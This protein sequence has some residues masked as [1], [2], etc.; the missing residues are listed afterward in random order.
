[1]L[2]FLVARGEVAIVGRQG[3]Q[4]IW[5]LASRVYPTDLPRLTPEEA[6]RMRDERR[7]RPREAR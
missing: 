5:D 3:R 4:R 1:M 2:E 7:L 6:K